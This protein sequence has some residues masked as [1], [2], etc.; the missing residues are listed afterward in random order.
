MSL[1]NY[2]A[3]IVYIV[4]ILIFGILYFLSYKCKS[5]IWFIIVLLTLI[6]ISSVINMDLKEICRLYGMEKPPNTVEILIESFNLNGFMQTLVTAIFLPVFLVRV[7]KIEDEKNKENKIEDSKGSI[8]ED[9][10][11]NNKRKNKKGKDKKGKTKR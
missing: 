1:F 10:E 4:A 9:D 7:L 2:P 5:K 6:V 8:K 3:I 11:E